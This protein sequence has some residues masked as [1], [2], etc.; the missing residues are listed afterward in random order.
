MRTAYCLALAATLLSLPAAG[1]TITLFYGDNDGFGI[2]ATTFK[3]PTVNSASGGEAAGTDVQRIG[4][5]CSAPGFAPTSTLSFGAI[6]G[7][8]SIQITM[9]LNGFGG[10]TAP[11][12]G[13]NS[14]VLD[15]MAVPV[16]FL[17]GFGSFLDS[18]NPNI[19]TRSAFL[20]A[21]FFPL[22]ADGSVNL[23]GTRITERDGFQSFQVDYIRF[24]VNTDAAVP[25]PASLGVVGLGLTA[26]GL[27]L[28]RRAAG[29]R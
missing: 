1:A 24:D 13:P 29:R 23:T 15:G 27:L 28:R 14:I 20:P 2:G 26:L 6:A 7:I 16:S 18:A 4:T 25:E 21:G 12:D 9:S 22:F 10:D 5:C 3:D 11:V 17:G 19:E 8:T